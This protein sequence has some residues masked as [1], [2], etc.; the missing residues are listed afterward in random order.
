M[1]YGNKWNYGKARK[2]GGI[3]QENENTERCF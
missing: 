2:F 1:L 3:V